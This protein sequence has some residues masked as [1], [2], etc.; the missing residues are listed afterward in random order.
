MCI[1]GHKRDCATA[2]MPCQ[3]ML[4][5]SSCLCRQGTGKRLARADGWCIHICQF[6][7]YTCRTEGEQTYRPLNRRARKSAGAPAQV[8]RVSTTTT[9]TTSLC[10]GRHAH[11]IVSGAQEEEHHFHKHIAVSCGCCC[12][13]AGVSL[14]IGRSSASIYLYTFIPLYIIDISFIYIG[15]Y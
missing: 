1:G 3:A 11:R 13:L 12:W 8:N 4:I 14:A 15:I 6:T 7:I 2:A 9:T 5:S 10:N